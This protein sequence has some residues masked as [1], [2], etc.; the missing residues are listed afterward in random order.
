MR[1]TA[2][3]AAASALAVSI[4]A[5]TGE[6]TADPNIPGAGDASGS[7]A[8]KPKANADGT[9]TVSY[10][11][12]GTTKKASITWTTP[13]GVEQDSE[14]KL[15]WTKTLKFKNADA[16]SV[17][18]QSAGDLAGPGTAGGTITCEIKVDGKVVKKGS[19]KG[20]FAVVSCDG[21]I[22]F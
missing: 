17:S 14:A 11:V 7:P 5:C 1:K 10:T 8:A 22:G 21:L 18:G 6:T 2:I 15:P 20:E 12:A 16:I 13:S 9:H 3:V 4:S 19:S